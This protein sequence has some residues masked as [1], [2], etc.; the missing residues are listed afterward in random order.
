MCTVR[1][2]L[3]WVWD[4]Q[5]TMLLSRS[6]D[7][8]GYV[9]PTREVLAAVRGTNAY[10]HYNGIQAWKIDRDGSVGHATA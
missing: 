4:G 9:Q 10:Y 1:F 2:T 3:P 8:T 7:E 5:P 6:T